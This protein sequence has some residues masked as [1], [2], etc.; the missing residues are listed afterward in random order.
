MEQ[1]YQSLVDYFGTQQKT[2]QALNVD[3]TTVSGWVCGKWSMSARAAM[4]AERITEGDFTKE[5]LCPAVF[6]ESETDPAA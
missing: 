4:R 3:Q 6:S 1:L 5:R 2:A